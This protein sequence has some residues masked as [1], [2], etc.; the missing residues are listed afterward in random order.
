[1][2]TPKTREV[3]THRVDTEV[4]TMGCRVNRLVVVVVV[5]VVVVVVVSAT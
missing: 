2:A 5:E 3:A 4:V 1:M